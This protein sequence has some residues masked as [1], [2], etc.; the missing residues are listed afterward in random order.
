MNSSNHLIYVSIKTIISFKST[1]VNL[2]YFKNN[3]CMFAFG[4]GRY[5]LCSYVTGIPSITKYVHILF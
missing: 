5:L 2:I 4:L 3:S 1:V